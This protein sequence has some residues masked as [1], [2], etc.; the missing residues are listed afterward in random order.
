[1]NIFVLDGDP[2]RAAQ[3]V[4]DTHCS[5]M[6]VE[7]A[8]ILCTVARALGSTNEKLYKSTHVHHPCVLWA[9]ETSMNYIWLVEH[10]VELG[11]EFSRRYGHAHSSTNVIIECCTDKSFTVP[12][13]RLTPHALAMPEQ[14][15][16]ADAVTAYRNYYFHEKR[17]FAKWNHGQTPQWLIDMLERCDQ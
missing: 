7:S 3:Y 1:M 17:G 6:L 10:A 12:T 16:C 11:F 5:K 13:G 2:R 8:Q 14:Y 9:K 15:R 4:C